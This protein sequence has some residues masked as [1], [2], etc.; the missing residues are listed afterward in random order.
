M[1][2]GERH[3]HPYSDEYDWLGPDLMQNTP[4]QYI[5]I[6]PVVL[7]IPTRMVLMIGPKSGSHYP[8]SAWRLI[9][10]VYDRIFSARVQQ[11][12]FIAVLKNDQSK[13]I[14]V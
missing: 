13:I 12:V 14:F 7:I 4:G 11:V 1:E 6:F 2:Y 9:Q 3:F 10:Y 8:H 5:V